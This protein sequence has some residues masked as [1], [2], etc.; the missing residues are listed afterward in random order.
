MP[1]GTRIL[2]GS[3]FAY[4]GI[5]H[6]NLPV[7][8][9]TTDGLFS[10]C[11]SLRSCCFCVGSHF[12]FNGKAFVFCYSLERIVTNYLSAWYEYGYR[13]CVKL[14][15]V[16]LLGNLKEIVANA[17]NSCYSLKEIIAPDKTLK[18]GANAFE[19]CYSLQTVEVAGF[20]SIAN[21]AFLNSAPKLIIRTQTEPGTLNADLSN[22]S[23]IY[24]PQEFIDNAQSATNWTN[25]TS[26]MRALEDYTVDGTTSGALDP[27]KI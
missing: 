4:S 1:A 16:R 25:Y 13:Q 12:A 27:T 11:F 14:R 8:E 23:Y 20:S 5:T 19:S 22:I 6:V 7:L 2:P 9:A 24:A 21:N 10:A 18:I 17:F 3:L 26:K 15:C